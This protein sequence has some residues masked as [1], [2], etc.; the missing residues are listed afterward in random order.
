MAASSKAQ[1]QA[2]Q[3]VGQQFETL[4][5]HLRE[6]LDE[7]G[8]EAAAERRALE[9]STR[10]LVATIEKGFS[11]AAP[12][13]KDPR[14]RHD[15]TEVGAA[16]RAAVGVTIGISTQAGPTKPATKST[17]KRTTKSTATG[18]TKPPAKRTAK[19]AT[20]RAVKRAAKPAAK[21]SAKGT[22]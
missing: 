12:V 7:V 15:L 10:Q 20:K 2:W 17:T 13:V 22:S 9:K 16:I 6:R 3:A 11:V 1:A 18:T 8:V 14:L 5:G 4:A 19:P 21:P